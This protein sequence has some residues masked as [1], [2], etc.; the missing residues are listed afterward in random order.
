LS[1]IAV[2]LAIAPL[3]KEID[4]GKILKF[5]PW[6]GASPENEMKEIDYPCQIEWLPNEYVPPKLGDF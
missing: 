4:C 3:V 2:N 1:K 5:G 6:D